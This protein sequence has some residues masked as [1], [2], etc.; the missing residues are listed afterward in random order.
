[1]VREFIEEV[2]STVHNEVDQFGGDEAV[3]QASG[4]SDIRRHHGGFAMLVIVGVD[5][6]K[7]PTDG[8]QQV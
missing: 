2:D 4:A 1:M 8:R 3:A 7:V 5:Q 6:V